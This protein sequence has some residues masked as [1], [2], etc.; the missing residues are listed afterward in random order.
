M[1]LLKTKLI[2]PFFI[3]ISIGCYANEIKELDRL[4]VKG[5]SFVNSENE[6]FVFRGLNAS[7]P[8]HLENLGHWNKSYFEEIKKWGANIVRL[9]VHPADWNER[10]KEAYLKLLNDGIQWATTLG[11]YVIIDWHS[12]GN[13][14]T[15]MFQ[16]DRYDTTLKETYDFWRTI[17]SEYGNNTTV[18]FY[19]IFNEPTT[20]GGT[21]GSANWDTWKTINEEVIGIIRA[22]GGEGIPLVAGFN[23]AYD[24]TPVLNEPL[25][26]E[27]IGYVSH[28][29]P[30]KRKQPWDA[31]WTKDWG[32][33]KDKYPLI[34]TEVGFCGPDDLGAHLPVIS[35]ESYG[36]AITKYCDDNEISY[37]VWVFDAQWAPR[38]F[39]DWDSYKPSRQGEYFKKKLQSYNY[40]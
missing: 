14:Q 30:Q 21:L 23:W 7:D 1:R 6:T 32:F 11:L 39:E 20:Y 4:T 9:P 40:D 36:E 17:A 33:V 3:L 27:G 28:P 37:V 31:Q 35:D 13:L 12:I 2:I 22:N 5:N 16:S 34:L 26:A 15:E 38:L 25:D 8:N 19:E 10:G 24:L 18:A 29:Y